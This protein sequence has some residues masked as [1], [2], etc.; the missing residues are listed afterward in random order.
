MTEG[1]LLARNPHDPNP[2]TRVS[3]VAAA[4]ALRYRETQGVSI[5]SHLNRRQNVFEEPRN[6]RFPSESESV[7]Q[8]P[9]LTVYICQF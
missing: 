9:D 4:A 2:S 1:S 7:L 5:S 3:N 6:S 8:G